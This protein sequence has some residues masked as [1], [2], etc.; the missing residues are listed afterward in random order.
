[1]FDELETKAK[2]ITDLMEKG[3]EEITIVGD[4]IKVTK[5]LYQKMIKGNYPEHSQTQIVNVTLQT[6]A[7]NI[8]KI[9]LQIDKAFENLKSLDI[10]KDRI[11]ELEHNIEIIKSELSNKKP[12]KN[13]LLNVI[14]CA[15]NIGWEVFSKLAPI[16]L[17]IVN[18]SV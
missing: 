4:N 12:D 6:T 9:N 7:Q 15:C 17:K 5:N 8:T 10:M 13:K 18:I 11:D 14:K 3:A 16:I 1:M 2:I